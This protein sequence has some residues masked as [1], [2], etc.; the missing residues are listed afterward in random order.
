MSWTKLKAFLVL[1]QPSSK[2]TVLGFLLRLPP[3]SRDARLNS[4][5]AVSALS[6][7]PCPSFDSNKFSFPAFEDLAGSLIE[8]RRCRHSALCVLPKFG[9]HGI[10]QRP[11]VADA[12]LFRKLSSYA[13]HNLLQDTRLESQSTTTFYLLIVFPFPSLS[14]TASASNNFTLHR[15]ASCNTAEKVSIPLDLHTPPFPPARLCFFS[16][17]YR[18]S[19]IGLSVLGSPFVSC[20]RTLSPTLSRLAAPFLYAGVMLVRRPKIRCRDAL[21]E[22]IVSLFSTPQPK[23]DGLGRYIIQKRAEKIQYENDNH[24]HDNDAI[25]ITLRPPFSLVQNTRISQRKPSW[26]HLSVFYRV[27]IGRTRNTTFLSSSS[28]SSSFIATESSAYSRSVNARD[29]PCPCC[30]FFSCAKSLVLRP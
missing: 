29:L 15:L 27:R 6:L 16:H 26:V 17:T 4:V 25:V 20:S 9:R 30:C 2:E 23:S 13:L 5:S 10:L 8:Q 19:C 12:F 3:P 24:N 22:R 14:T 1:D 7:F 21:T 18:V 11:F 28:C